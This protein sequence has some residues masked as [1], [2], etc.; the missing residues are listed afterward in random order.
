[1]PPRIFGAW[2][3]R[4]P[5]S[6]RPKNPERRRRPSNPNLRRSASPAGSRPSRGGQDP[7]VYDETWNEAEKLAGCMPDG[8][9]RQLPPLLGALLLAHAC[10]DEP[11]SGA[12]PR[13]SRRPLSARPRRTKTICSFYLGLAVCG[14]QER[15]HNFFRLITSARARDRSKPAPA[16][17]ASTT[18]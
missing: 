13:A 18:G 7:F 5:G 12:R 14:P 2:P 6:P 16:G 15:P 11:I 10:R 9:G 4:A 8:R 1:V 17:L 3:D